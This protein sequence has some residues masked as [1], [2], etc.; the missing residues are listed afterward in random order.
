M[1]CFYTVFA[2][3]AISGCKHP[4][5]SRFNCFAELLLM[6]HGLS[7]AFGMVARPT[8][9]L[10]CN[11]NNTRNALTAYNNSNRYSVKMFHALPARVA[12]Y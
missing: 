5:V 12:V 2:G 3:R 9:R 11:Y 1:V 7:T 4:T 8:T 10:S 6:K